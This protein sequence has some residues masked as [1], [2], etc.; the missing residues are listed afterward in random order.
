MKRSYWLKEKGFENIK[1]FVMDWS[2]G[3]GY[4]GYVDFS[5]VAK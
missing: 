4:L 5:E 2:S 3:D 1:G